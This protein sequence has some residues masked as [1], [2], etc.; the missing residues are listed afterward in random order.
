V[1]VDKVSRWSSVRK[2][3]L[4]EYLLAS[5]SFKV[6]ELALQGHKVEGKGM[7]RLP[8]FGPCIDM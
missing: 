3:L 5:K 8:G 2:W 6:P 7:S 1:D 4:A